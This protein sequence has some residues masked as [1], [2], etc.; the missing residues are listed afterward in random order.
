MS[1]PIL[2]LLTKSSYNCQ[3]HMNH[4]WRAV[5]FYSHVSFC[6]VANNVRVIT[7]RVF[8]TNRTYQFRSQFSAGIQNYDQ[9]HHQRFSY[10]TFSSSCW[11]KGGASRWQLLFVTS[12]QTL[13]QKKNEYP[14]GCIYN[15]SFYCQQVK[16]Q[17]W[18]NSPLQTHSPNHAQHMV[19]T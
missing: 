6:G 19:F 5:L 18:S 13:N 10:A 2:T 7:K 15:I 9:M 4:R 12:Q 11:D 16:R 14:L 1:Y 3:Q 8:A 17:N